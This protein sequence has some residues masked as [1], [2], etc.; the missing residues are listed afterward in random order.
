MCVSKGFSHVHQNQNLNV[1]WTRGARFNDDETKIRINNQYTKGQAI[2]DI[3]DIWNNASYDIRNAGNLFS[4]K[5]MLKNKINTDMNECT[6]VDCYSCR[7]DVHSDYS[8]YMKI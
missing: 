8:K 6:T 5:R 7:I 1:L 4:L 3:L 2:F